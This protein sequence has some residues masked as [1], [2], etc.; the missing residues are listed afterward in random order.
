MKHQFTWQKLRVF[1]SVLRQR[2]DAIYS[3][4]KPPKMQHEW[5]TNRLVKQIDGIQ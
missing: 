1:V 5:Y 4:E 2:I 3:C